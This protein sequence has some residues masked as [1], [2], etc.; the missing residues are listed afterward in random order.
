M[1][2]TPIESDY[3]FLVDELRRIMDN[4]NGVHSIEAI[5]FILDMDPL[6]EEYLP[7]AAPLGSFSHYDRVTTLP[8]IFYRK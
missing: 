3:A 1:S 4:W 7:E 2:R 5:R 8:E 6:C